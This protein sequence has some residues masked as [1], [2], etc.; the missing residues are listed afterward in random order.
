MAMEEVLLGRKMSLICSN[1]SSS[2]VILIYVDVLALALV[3]MYP[4]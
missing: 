3:I 4:A 1:V 2:D